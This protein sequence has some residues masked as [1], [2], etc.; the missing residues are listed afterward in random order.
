[1]YG[2]SSGSKAHISIVRLG[3]ASGSIR[4]PMVIFEEACLSYELT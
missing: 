1:M 2:R 3:N 4:A